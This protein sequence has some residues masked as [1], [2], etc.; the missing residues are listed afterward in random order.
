MTESNGFEHP[1]DLDE[2]VRDIQRLAAE[3][4]PESVRLQERL[5]PSVSHSIRPRMI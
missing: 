1:H 3:R 4:H 2:T 5:P